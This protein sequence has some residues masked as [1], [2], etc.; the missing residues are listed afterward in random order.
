[1]TKT[2]LAFYH[3]A[4]L[5]L[6]A[7]EKEFRV[8]KLWQEQDPEET[9]QRY[10]DSAVGIICWPNTPPISRR[11]IEALPNLE[12][13][14][15]FGVGYDNIDIEAARQREVVV[16]NT[17]D[18]VTNDTADTA[19]GL[20]LMVARRFVEADAYIR[21]GKWEVGGSP[22]GFLGHRLYGKTV[23]IVGLGRI[24]AAISKRAE[25]FGCTI[26]Y[27][28]RSPKDAPYE[29]VQN[30]KELAQQS[31]FLVLSCSATPKTI[32]VVNLEVMEALGPQGYLV[33]ISRGSVVNEEDL[34]IAL[35]NKS[36]AGAGLDVFEKEP[37][38][39]EAMKTMDN[40]VLLPHIGTAT[41]ETRA[42]MAKLVIE[43]IRLWFQRGE[44]LTRVV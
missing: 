3:L 21:V 39:P 43:N 42:E 37:Y 34:L 26:K 1:M 22:K 30:I 38:V 7:L 14:S 5:G 29:F 15:Q 44:T 19:L 13:I 24:G 20:M 9:I 6:D 2:I 25:A 27:T 33:N 32:G 18:L 10:R 31:D 8:I 16:C 4:P 35:R 12:I 11:V 28:G 40:V 41:Y 36:I 23:G 17:P